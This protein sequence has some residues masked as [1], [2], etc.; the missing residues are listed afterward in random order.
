VSVVFGIGLSGLL[1]SYVIVIRE[2]Y[3]VREANWRVPTV[4]FAG[5]LGMAMGGWLPG[6]L[7]DRFA[8]YLPAF[9]TGLA[10]NVVN[11]AV[12][13]FLVARRQRSLPVL[14]AP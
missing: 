10:L 2:C 11:F 5:F 4:M 7:F 14:A 3:T 6:D 1:P 9:G 12:L 13:L 8:S